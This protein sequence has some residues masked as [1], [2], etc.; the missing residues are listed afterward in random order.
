MEN[1]YCW[2][3]IFSCCII[4]S[5][6]TKEKR[7]DS[8]V[9]SPQETYLSFPVDE[10]TCLPK[11]CLWAF[12]DNQ[13]EYIAFDNQGDEILFY[14][15][16]TQHLV[17][18]VRFDREGEN[19]II[20][21][22]SFYVKDFNNIYI[23]SP[24][25]GVFVTDTTAKI[26]QKIDF[27][28]LKGKFPLIRFL[29][30]TITHSP[31]C[32]IN[33]KLYIPQPVNPL[34]GGNFLPR[35]PIGALLDT[36]SGTKEITPLT[37]L[38]YVPTSDIPSYVRGITVSHCYDGEKLLYS[39]D[40]ED[41]LITLSSDFSKEKSYIAKSRYIDKVEVR[42]IKGMDLN[43]ALKKNCETAGYGN[44]VYDKYRQVY[45]RFVYPDVE[46]DKND[47]NYM[48]ILHWGGKQ[49]SIIILDKK[50]NVIGETLFPEYTYNSRLFFICKDG[51][52]LSTTHFKRPDFDENILRFQ[53]IELKKI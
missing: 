20:A 39:F 17:K 29:S 53:K 47:I 6:T 11:F 26:K 46:L 8:Y 16:R 37:Y 5:C 40:T 34:L 50:M 35:S 18:K 51:L 28:Q 38:S 13:N 25:G 48:D 14:D 4:I 23:P 41:S 52:F 15:V 3:A 21:I 10:E 7:N 9:L 36:I 30:T 2:V 44:I 31:I 27:S 22:N 19:G 1:R 32:F 45:Y 43:I 49:F 12:I 42:P 33:D 24:Q